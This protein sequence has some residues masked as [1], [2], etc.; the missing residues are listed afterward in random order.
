MERFYDGKKLLEDVSEALEVALSKHDLTAHSLLGITTV[1]EVVSSGLKLQCLQGIVGREMGCFGQKAYDQA[2]LARKVA[3]LQNPNSTTVNP[4]MEGIAV[5]LSH[6]TDPIPDSNLE[7]ATLRVF[8][9]RPRLSTAGLVR[10]KRENSSL[11]P[12]FVSARSYLEKAHMISK[13]DDGMAWKLS[14]LWEMD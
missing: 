10:A 1:L 14:E 6:A 2:R 3:L 8:L 4:L 5:A 11:A 9:K 13:T 12:A 7:C